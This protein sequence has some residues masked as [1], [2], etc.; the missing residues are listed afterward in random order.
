MEARMTKARILVVEDSRVIAMELEDR[1]QALGYR[2][3]AVV[4]SGE[5]AVKAA[6]RARPDLVLMDIKL[7]GDVDGIE[8]TT[9]IRA[10]L[11]IPIVY[12][13]A[14]A[15]EDTLQRAKLTEP[16]G[17]ILKPFEERELHTAIEMAL[18][19]H[20]MEKRLRESEQ[21]LATTLTSID[22]GVI[23]TDGSGWVAFIN[24]V[25]AALTGWPQSE[26]RGRRISEI[27]EVIH[28]SERAV[29]PNPAMQALKRGETVDL[30][31]HNLLTRD[32]ERIPI[33]GHSALIRDDGG[34]IR[35]VVLTF[36]DVSERKKD[37]RERE[38]LQ[39]QLFQAQQ[40]EAVGLLA[41]G[42]A[43]DYS[44]L[45]MTIVGYSSL[46]LADLDPEDA[47]YE[48]IMHIQEAGE[49][50]ASLTRQILALS[51]QQMPEP[52]VLDLNALIADMERTIHRLAGKQNEVVRVL[53]PDFGYIK[54]DPG[55]LEQLIINLV[56]NAKEA[57]LEGGELT[58]KTE[59]VTLDQDQVE[60]RL[61]AYPGTFVRL[62]VSDTGIGIEDE[63]LPQ[64]FEPF[65]STKETGSGLGLSIVQNT[66][67]QCDGWIEIESEIGRGS[68]FH[69]FFPVFWTDLEEP[70]TVELRPELMGHGERILLVEDDTRVRVAISEMLRAGG[71]EV[72]QAADA[73]EAIEV[74]EKQEGNLH[75]IF[76]DVVL[77]NR[78]G[79]QL[80]DQLHAWAPG[81]P[82]LLTSG[83]TDQQAQWP[84]IRE[85]GFRFLQKP[86]SLTQL[87]PVVREVLDG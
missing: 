4:S 32:E 45:L 27:F 48:E 64:L 50:A 51:R 55:Q 81:L 20:R 52:Q 83:Y 82:V 71:Y 47:L 40:M 15:D 59:N 9:A 1:L 41:G 42:L 33:E 84:A 56:L 19:K 49:K 65:Y 39:E 72:L 66:V 24:P 61:G 67:Q 26:V 8:A 21:W 2:L 44:N 25:A 57:M 18:Y 23:A 7:K 78:N 30:A 10:D 58:I 35:G 29:A 79:L 86:F 73:G 14:Y 12:L 37:E 38:R 11:D 22:D 77:P 36:R 34:N 76:A 3:E 13:T 31:R 70:P 28:E 43:H 75:M 16:Y 87:L 46:I 17:Y 69:I 80:V 54:A 60:H 53:E 68:A 5:Q 63:A 85:R 74:F 62:S 6:A